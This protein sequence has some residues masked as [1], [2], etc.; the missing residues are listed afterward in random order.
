[1]YM[2]EGGIRMICLLSS[3]VIWEFCQKVVM[4]VYELT[5]EKSKNSKM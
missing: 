1:M 4:V 3:Q 2:S 5:Y